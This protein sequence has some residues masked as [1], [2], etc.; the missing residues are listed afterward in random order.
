[1]Q[2]AVAG[3]LWTSRLLSLPAAPL[4]SHG[5]NLRV[6]YQLA[7]IG[8][9]NACFD[10]FELPPLDFEVGSHCLIEKVGAIPVSGIR[11][12]IELPQFFGIQAKAYSSFAHKPKS[13]GAL[14]CIA[15]HDNLHKRIRRP[16][17]GTLNFAAVGPASG[18]TLQHVVP[19]WAI[20]L[21]DE[22]GCLPLQVAL[23]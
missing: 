1:M 8:F 11:Q 23:P 10:L 22:E 13:Y 15:M 3:Q 17:S 21:S 6:F 19:L 5:S 12:S 18:I 4:G 20:L 16:R 14:G 7:G 2:R 9:R